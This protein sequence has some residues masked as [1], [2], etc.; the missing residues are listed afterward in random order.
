MVGLLVPIGI[1]ADKTS[2]NFISTITENKQLKAFIAF[3]NKRR[4]LFKDVHAE[5]QPTILIAAN[6][7]RA[8]PQF[9]Y[10]VKLH[11]LPT[12]Q[13]DPTVLMDAATLLAVNPNTGTVPIFRSSEDARIVAGAYSRVPVLVRKSGQGETKDWD[14]HYLTMFHM[15]NDSAHFRNKSELDGQ[16]GAWPI[17]NQRCQSAAGIWLPLYEGKSVQI[18]NHRY[19]SV[20]TPEGSISGQ[21]QAIHASLD[22]LA[23]PDFCPTPRYWV[24]ASEAQAI[25][26]GYAIGFNDVC[27]TNNERSLIAAVVPQVGAGNTL[28]LLDELDAS[29]CTLLVGNL[30]AIPCDYFARNKIQSRHLNKYILE[31]LPVIPPATYA[32]MFGPKSAADIVRAAVLELSYTAHDLAP[33]ARDMGHVDAKGEVLPPFAWDE[34]RRLNLRAKL[35][36]LYFILYGVFEPARAA[37]SREDVRYIYS[38]FPIVAE[39]E[40]EKWGSYKSE[41]LCLAWVNAL[42]A[43]QP[44][45][46]IG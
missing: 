26:R 28:P 10:A 36:A 11:A 35:D 2:A 21:G 37:E 15:T 34:A 24:K 7:G 17:G 33:F 43:G 41:E 39:K 13:A 46:V 1:G 32:R 31:Q 4:W 9:R 19:A 42:M 30:N 23:T 27:N 22:E 12:E 14:F 18:Y 25:K 8:Y 40:A 20:I 38:T 29:D 3:E 5:D 44:D 45:A 16:E 6:V